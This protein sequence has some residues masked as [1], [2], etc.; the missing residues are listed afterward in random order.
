M[1]QKGLIHHKTKQPNNQ[2]TRKVDNQNLIKCTTD[3]KSLKFLKMTKIQ[4]DK[5][6]LYF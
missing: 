3:K 1:T 6:I 5:I 4:R 2:P